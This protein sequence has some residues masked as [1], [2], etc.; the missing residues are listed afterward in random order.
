MT[1]AG[2]QILFA[3]IALSAAILIVLLLR[4][5]VRTAFGARLAYALWL[6]PPLA[7]LAGYLPPRVVDIAVLAAP[8]SPDILE[9]HNNVQDGA[10]PPPAVVATGIDPALVA[11]I[12][13]ISGGIAMTFWLSARQLSFQGDMRRGVAGPAVVGF[14][15]PRIVTPSDFES[16]F[17]ER[18]RRVVL[19]HE[20]IHL[21]MH[22]ARVNGVAAFLRCICWYNP[23]VHIAAHCLRIDQEMACDASVVERY[24]NARR[25]YA[26]ALLKAQLATRPLPLGCY[27][28]SGAEHPLT[29]RV[30]M[31]K[32]PSPGRARR[33][34]G[35]GVLSVVALSVGYVAWGVLP[36]ERIVEIPYERP[37]ASIAEANRPAELLPSQSARYL[38][39]PGAKYDH[40]DHIVVRGF[41]ERTYFTGDGLT[42]LIQASEIVRNGHSQPVTPGASLWRADPG[43]W[44]DQRKTG[45]WMQPGAE[46]RVEGYVA[47]DK[48]CAPECQL[49]W[50][51]MHTGLQPSVAPRLKAASRPIP[52]M[53]MASAATTSSSPPAA[54]PP[55]DASPPAPSV[56]EYSQASP[57]V[58]TADRLDGDSLTYT[59]NVELRVGDV[60]MKADKLTVERGGNSSASSG[61]A[62]EIDADQIGR[63]A[64]I[65][66]YSGNVVVRIDGV[67][68]N[69]DKLSVEQ[70]AAAITP[71][72]ASSPLRQPPGPLVPPVVPPV[73]P[74]LPV[75]P[76][77]APPHLP[78]N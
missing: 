8:S 77:A 71:A 78:Q 60:V 66:I 72:P 76:E 48:R 24:P 26:G 22:D 55:A 51:R 6:L 57:I 62:I 44:I 75:S 10:S 74:T 70:S 25:L 35:V 49:E 17:D 56:L 9:L 54:R 53:A 61:T 27:W 3:N 65:L 69:T 30:E 20:A 45:E 33:L 2:Q 15:R 32:R 59:G 43:A 38:P 29:E 47:R 63:D 21:R 50:L 19:A 1:D 12:T 14:L 7:V 16:K 36:E 13:W 42:A 31:L 37:P 52:T 5:P 34:A 39:P 73:A 28:P 58:V 67:T 64:G 68:L 40:N 4:K 18:E 23:L 11:F 46:I 41:I